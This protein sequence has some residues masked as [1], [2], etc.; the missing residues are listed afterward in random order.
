MFSAKVS[1][2]LP[3]KRF[4]GIS[5]QLNYCFSRKYFLSYDA[6]RQNQTQVS[7]ARQSGSKAIER[8]LELN[9]D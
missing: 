7:A 1:L 5:N 6:S 8:L 9:Y 4:A 2:K 3:E